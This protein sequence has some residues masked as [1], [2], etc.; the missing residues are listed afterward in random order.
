MGVLGYATVGLSCV[1]R[2]E[3][4]DV[5]PRG[6]RDCPILLEYVSTSRSLSSRYVPRDRIAEKTSEEV[7]S[8]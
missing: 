8:I 2:A 7:L 1:V 5:V 4:N 3:S 6:T